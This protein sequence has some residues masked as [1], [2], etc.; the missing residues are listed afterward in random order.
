M[1]SFS[2]ILLQWNKK[3]PRNLP[4]KK[5]K[6]AYSTWL[7]EIILQQTRVK[8]GIAYYLKFK[9]LF[10]TIFDLSNAKFKEILKAW[11]GLG[12]Y[13]RARN[14]HHTAQYVVNQLNGEFPK[15][16]KD[17]QK[18]KGIGPYTAAAIASFSF[19][20]QIAA[21]DGNVFRVLSRYFGIDTPIDSSK[22]KKEFTALA[23]QM[24]PD[25][26][27]AEFN[28]SMMNFG[29]ITCTPKA[30]DCTNCPFSASCFAFTNN[31]VYNLPVKKAK[32]RVKNRYFNYFI[33]EKKGK[34]LIEE[35]KNEKDVWQNLYQFP[36]VET[37][38][39]YAIGD[40][41]AEEPINNFNAKQFTIKQIWTDKQRLSHQHITGQFIWLNMEDECNLHV[42]DSQIVDRKELKKYP[43][44]KLI[45]NVIKKIS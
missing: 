14:L 11:E 7:S 25:G 23:N 24:L 21:V 2:D 36:L 13:S 1:R 20:E 44:P 30:A 38:K 32:Q 43:F 19:N 29:A 35:R 41:L 10:P 39:E 26:L 18:L 16:S 15:H 9:S 3:N 34:V 8:F 28:Q 5:D 42:F 22:G 45:Q 40:L 37:N 6:D 27:A 17:L 4:W 31:L 33:I 12:Y